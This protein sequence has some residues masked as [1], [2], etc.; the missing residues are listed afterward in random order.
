MMFSKPSSLGIL[1][2]F[3]KACAP[4]V[5]PGGELLRALLGGVSV[6]LCFFLKQWG[7]MPGE[8][9]PGHRQR[10]CCTGSQGPYESR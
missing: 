4:V 8:Q 1:S 6:L 10:V 2:A 3:G 7:R 5:L 9:G